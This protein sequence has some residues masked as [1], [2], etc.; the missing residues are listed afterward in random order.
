ML[1][2]FSSQLEQYN[3]PSISIQTRK[4]LNDDVL[5]ELFGEE[6]KQ[7]EGLR[8]LI[9]FFG[10]SISHEKSDHNT[11]HVVSSLMAPEDRMMVGF[12]LIKE[13]E[14]MRKAYNCPEF[15]AV[16]TNYLTVL[17]EEFGADFN[18]EQFRFVSAW[19]H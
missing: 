3:S 2:D 5:Q 16:T 11:M 9:L 14:I 12:D 7:L 8:T 13:T 17:N 4:G 18:L 15:K 10:A 6:K 1:D 19:D